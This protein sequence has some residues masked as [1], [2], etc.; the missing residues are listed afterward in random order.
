MN[1][2]IRRPKNGDTGSGYQN[3]VFAGPPGTGKT[4]VA[5]IMARVLAGLDVLKCGADVKCISK[6]DLTSQFKGG[7]EHE[8]EKVLESFKG[9]VL[10]YINHATGGVFA[11]SSDTCS[12]SDTDLRVVTTP[13][14][15]RSILFW[16]EA[17]ELAGGYGPQLATSLVRYLSK[18]KRDVVLIIAGY[19][20]ALETGFFSVRHVVCV[21]P[22]FV[23]SSVLA[24]CVVLALDLK[25]Q[26]EYDIL[27][28]QALQ[29]HHT[30]SLT[31]NP[32]KGEHW[33]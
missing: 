2:H 13:F 7:T 5:G 21:V 6:K 17:Y 18:N 9:Y 23:E 33:A 24:F 22:A 29:S 12:P 15:C 28:L 11:F 4:V 20:A 10:E 19:K 30:S 1:A 27:T 3:M 25:L 31:P 14:V 32:R 8:A 26:V 16:D